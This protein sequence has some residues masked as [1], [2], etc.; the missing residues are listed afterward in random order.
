MLKYRVAFLW[1]D[2]AMVSTRRPPESHAVLL[3]R[4]DPA[5]GGEELLPGAGADGWPMKR[6]PAME[7]Q[8]Q[9]KPSKK[10]DFASGGIGTKCLAR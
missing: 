1:R 2:T 3:N 5:R 10:L 9:E 7:Y 8:N 4:G 6:S